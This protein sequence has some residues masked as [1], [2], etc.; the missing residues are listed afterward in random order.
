MKILV[1]NGKWNVNFGQVKLEIK[2]KYD[3][4]NKLFSL[5]FYNENEI[6]KIKSKNID[7]TLAFLEKKLVA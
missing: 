2:V 3:R 4:K 5:E 6:I 1:K 7:K